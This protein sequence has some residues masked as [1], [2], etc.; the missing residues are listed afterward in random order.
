MGLQPL[1][2]TGLSFTCGLAILAAVP[3]VPRSGTSPTGNVITRRRPG[4]TATAR[5]SS[6]VLRRSIEVTEFG[7]LN[8]A[9][10]FCFG[11]SAR[12]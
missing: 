8:D 11:F 1:A 12:T 10:C 2:V 7:G 3:T 9:F 5:T 6:S 4:W